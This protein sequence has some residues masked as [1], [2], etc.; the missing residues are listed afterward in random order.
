MASRLNQI[1]CKTNS[2]IVLLALLAKKATKNRHARTFFDHVYD[3]V[4]IIIALKGN[5]IFTAYR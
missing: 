1:F 4:A 2:S 5:D 3:D